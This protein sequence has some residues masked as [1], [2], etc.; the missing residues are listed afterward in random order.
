MRKKNIKVFISYSWDSKEHELWVL[1][2]ANRLRDK[3]LDVILDK[4]E[5]RLGNDLNFFMEKSVKRADRV[6][7]IFTKNYK[8]KAEKRHGG[9]GYEYSIITS[10]F[11]KNRTSN[12][13]FLPI[14]R[15]GTFDKSVPLNF[16]SNLLLNMTSDLKFDENFDYLTREI[17][18]QP[19]LKKPR[20]GKKPEFESFI[21]SE[22]LTCIDRK[23]IL[24]IE[25]ETG[26]RALCYDS[27]KFLV[28]KDR[29][30]YEDVFS[31]DS[32]FVEDIKTSPGAVIKSRNE[33]GKFIVKTQLDKLYKKG[34]ILEYNSSCR[35]LN[36]H[37]EDT[38]Y[39]SVWSE[40]KM[41]KLE[42]IVCFPLERKYKLFN[43]YKKSTVLDRKKINA[44]SLVKE[45][46]YLDLPA[47]K[48]YVE[49]LEVQD[50]YSI[51]WS[52]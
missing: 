49:N 2:L 17:Y 39:F 36:C 45:I 24:H 31:S 1:N 47:V 12:T 16:V 7:I 8:L 37:S 4:Y 33:N 18:Q 6:L 9:V 51:E 44:N 23:V 52:W 11:I 26:D 21:V 28:L 5:I 15:E 14:L 20:L 27:M 10:Q 38:S 42:I 43:G 35:Y 41:L 22:E 34:E 46:T 3:G 32:S 19:K 13:K 48:L 40:Y 30:Y 50:K 29:D 25:D